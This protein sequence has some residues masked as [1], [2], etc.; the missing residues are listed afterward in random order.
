MNISKFNEVISKF[1]EDCNYPLTAKNQLVIFN[2]LLKRFM[3]L[4]EFENIDKTINLRELM[5]SII[6]NDSYMILELDGELRNVYG[7]LAGDLDFYGYPT[8]YL[9]STGVRSGD[10][11]IEDGVVGHSNSLWTPLAPT[12]LYYSKMLAG[13]DTSL[14]IASVNTRLTPVYR[15]TTDTER[16]QI[17]SVF[18]AIKKGEQKFVCMHKQTLKDLAD[19]NGNYTIDLTGASGDH[20][21]IPM[22]LQAYDNILAR[23]CRE[24]GINIS[25]QMKRAQVISAELNGYENYTQIFLDDMLKNIRE[26]FNAVNARWDRD[27]KVRLS[28]AFTDD[29]PVDAGADSSA[30]KGADSNAD[31]SAGSNAGDIAGGDGKEEE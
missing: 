26:S 14:D 22:L 2:N 6:F 12:M 11:A 24:L 1:C 31:L 18:N 5:L 27:W 15:A 13:L 19:E 10:N 16:Q 3:N 29:N 23:V 25:T 9:W 8:R 28:E 7:G 17:E 20:T 21:Y 30:D 4:F